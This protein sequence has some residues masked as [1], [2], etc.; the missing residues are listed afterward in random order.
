MTCPPAHQLPDLASCQ[1]A[2]TWELLSP[3][4]RHATAS[5]RAPQPHSFALPDAALSNWAAIHR[6]GLAGAHT[7]RT[8]AH[9]RP[10]GQISQQRG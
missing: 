8:Q 6:W 10:E 7:K 3:P 1:A 5:V 9:A 4:L 2:S